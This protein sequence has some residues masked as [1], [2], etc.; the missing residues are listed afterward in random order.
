LYN[1]DLS[2]RRADSAVAYIVS[3]GIDK[4]RLVAAGYG[5]SQLVN[6]CECEGKYVKRVC[7]EEEH[8]MNRRTTI[9]L[10]GNDYV[11]KNKEEMKKSEDKTQVNPQ[12][13]G[14]QPPPKK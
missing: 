14:N 3:R 7:S 10:L 4:E 1:K 13:R 9:R 5:E 12:Q 8:Q 2:Q 11:P 6:D